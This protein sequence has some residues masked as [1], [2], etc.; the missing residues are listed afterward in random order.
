M[1]RTLGVCYYPEHWEESQWAIDAARMAEVGLTWVRI[2]EFAWSRMEPSYGQYDLGWLDRA[3]ETLGG[4]G[5]KVVLGT[6]TATPPR[7]MLNRHPDMLAHD[8]MGNPRGFGSRRHY[9]FAHEGYRSDCARITEV[10]AKRYGANPYVAAWQTDNEYACH[11][12]VLSYSPTALAA[13]RNWLAQKYQSPQALNRAWGN[14]FWSMEYASFDEVGLPNLTVTEANPAHVMDFRRFSSQMV[15]E[16]NRIQ[17]DIIRAHSPAPIAHNYMG[18]V[19]DFDH[20]A[21]GADLDI[22]SWDAYPIGFLSDRVVASPE[23]KR[24]FLR[25][26]DPDFQAFHHDLYRAVGAQR[27][28]GSVAAGRWWIMEQQPGPVNWAPWNPD[29]LPGMARL[30]AHEAFAHGA[31]AVCYFRWRQ[32][33]FAQ[34]QMHA[35]LLRPDS[36]PAPAY[37]EAME[38]AREIA[39]M[40]QV[41]TARA[42]VGLVF[43]YASDWAWAT[44]PQ[45]RDFSY[46]RLVFE[47]YRGLRRLGLNV[48][49]LPP[50]TGDLSPYALVLAPGVATLTDAFLA[51]LRSHKGLS[52][53]GPRSNSKTADFAIPVPLPPN[54]PNLDA[55]VARVES[56]PPDCSEALA[57][58]AAFVHWREKVETSAEVVERTADG[59]PAL[60]RSGGIHYLAGWADAAALARILSNLCDEAGIETTP[61]PEGLRLRDSATHRYLFNYNAFAVEWDGRTIAPAGVD[62]QTL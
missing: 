52:L 11:N 7:W 21:V 41:G 25:Q 10:L 31:E 26:G 5:L 38:V 48:D 47:T 27:Q 18:Q 49:I 39:A 60:I 12:T 22:A 24:R 6:P 37:H 58:G 33:P 13:F 62:W 44:Q 40:P 35:G 57:M 8:K 30:W 34:E 9:D 56:M 29:P 15:V 19:T 32:A 55:T 42:R 16:F 17:T 20:F 4:A 54:L 28:G 1:N 3:I 45:G 36:A 50:H 59:W 14:V 46:F 61:L 43:D 51:A 23:Y 53:I 2:G